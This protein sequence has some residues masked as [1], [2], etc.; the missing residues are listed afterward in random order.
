MIQISLR[1]FIKY[2]TYITNIIVVI[3]P[4]GIG[5]HFSENLAI[6]FYHNVISKRGNI[7]HW[8]V[9]NDIKIVFKAV[10]NII[11]KLAGR[12]SFPFISIIRYF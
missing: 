2:F 9:R 5:I 8:I 3:I 10:L 12:L 1:N 4:V 7:H 6:V 11:I